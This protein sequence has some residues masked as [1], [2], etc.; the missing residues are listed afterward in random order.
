[1][2]SGILVWKKPATL[3]LPDIV[4]WVR[5]KF[6][7]RDVSAIIAFAGSLVCIIVLSLISYVIPLKYKIQESRSVLGT[8]GN[9]LPKDN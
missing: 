1:M 5:N 2:G 9:Y 4:Q 3:F 6:P 8:K 7:S